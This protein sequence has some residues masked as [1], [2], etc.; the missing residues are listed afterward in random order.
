MTEGRAVHEIAWDGRGGYVVAE[1][2]A[3]HAYACRFWHTGKRHGPC[4][5]GAL[6][7]WQMAAVQRV[8]ARVMDRP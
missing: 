6:E 4:T 8:I 1:V 3:V 2:V 5:C 7:L